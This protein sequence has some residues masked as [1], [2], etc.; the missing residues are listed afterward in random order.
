MKEPESRDLTFKVQGFTYRQWFV[1]GILTALTIF[2]LAGLV[3][4]IRNSL[5]ELEKVA[6]PAPTLVV[7]TPTVSL[8]LTEAAEEQTPTEP[9]TV[10]AA[11]ATSS[12]V[13]ESTPTPE[14]T[15]TPVLFPTPIWRALPVPSE[16]ALRDQVAWMSLEDKIGQMVMVGFSGQS[17]AG[18]AELRTMIGTY[19]VGGVVL[20]ES[21]AHDPQQLSAL[22]GEVQE[23][24]LASG[25]KIPL[26]IAI[27]H[28]G[29]IVVRITEGVTEFPGNMAVAAT[30]RPEN[31]YTAAAI[32]AQEL[33]AMGVSMNLAPVLDVND[34][35]WN[36]VIGTRSFG[37]DPAR[38]AEYGQL[39]VRGSQEH[40]VIAIAKHFPG[41]GSV[42]VDSHGGLPVI[43]DAVDVLMQ[44]ELKPFS[45]AMQSGLAG[46]M[47]A[48]IA[49][50]A[51]DSSGLPATLSAPIL[52]GL[53][54]DQMA[55]DGLLMTDSLGMAGVSAG[56]GQAQAAV[57]A[58]RA[59]VDILLSTTPMEAH[60]A[61]IQ[62]LVAAVGRGELSVERIDQSIIR[63]LRVK[64]AY[65][66]YQAPTASLAVVN[67]P[68][69]QVIAEEIARQSVT[70]I[71]DADKNIPIAPTTR[72]LVISPD[73]LPPAA[74]GQG[75][76]FGE[77]LKERGYDVMEQVLNL[78]SQDGRNAVY[79]AARM[80][81]YDGIVFGEW[82]LIKRQVNE[83]D[84]WQ[85]TLIAYLSDLGKPLIVVAWHNPAAALKCPANATVITAYGNA[86]SQVTAIVAALTGELVPTGQLP[87]VLR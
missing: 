71:Q 20:L 82:E 10:I 48:H 56:R 26:F 51:L 25:A 28:E 53:L 87:M 68:E 4:F 16:E 30:R 7:S 74:T 86:R 18:S 34:N 84:T 11:T 6:A 12:P 65:G 45:V 15:S 54:R 46:I 64:Y 1:L 5:K 22:T 78:N 39:A 17:L 79:A 31:A 42:A 40:G 81:T 73:Q 24:A 66:L 36:P 33:R 55:Y 77:M 2:V 21:N 60:I 61:I 29:G 37:A 32:A 83:G 80:N 14:S 13:P 41:H 72:L 67:S 47:T 19:H 52:T 9:P 70:L 44:R 75:T 63:I 38:V 59:G 3:L 49:V 43:T 57:E 27:N 69:H 62:S 85:E 23:L 58:V 8:I 76:L 35:P 50:P